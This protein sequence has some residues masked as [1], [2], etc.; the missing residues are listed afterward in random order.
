MESRI[1]TMLGF[2]KLCF[3]LCLA[4][5]GCGD[6]LP[7]S[8][9]D[10]PPRFRPL[11]TLKQ[12]RSVPRDVL[13]TRGS[14]CYT[15]DVGAFLAHDDVDR[16]SVLVHE[17]LHAARQLADHRGVDGWMRQYETDDAF[18]FDEERLGWAVEIEYLVR[19]GRAVNF[20]KVA[21]A[22]STLYPSRT[23]SGSVFD[24]EGS[25]AWAISVAE[26]ALK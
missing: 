15:G 18:V 20:D 4:L 22:M 16:S 7:P 17:A 11:T 19:H 2:W 8:S 6:V 25:R 3:P 24:R 13:A 9:I 1:A 14:T 12:S 23:G 10:L 5:V 26:E 21:D